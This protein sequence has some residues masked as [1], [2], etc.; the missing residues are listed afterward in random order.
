MVFASFAIGCL[1]PSAIS[2]DPHVEYVVFTP[3]PRARTVRWV[4]PA[5]RLET[6]ET[7]PAETF[8]LLRERFVTA[9][10][11]AADTRKPCPWPSKDNS[12]LSCAGVP[13]N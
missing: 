10:L 1:P 4:N 12:G 3:L 5:G 13:P 2:A 7:M 8:P 6:L 9:K 11:S